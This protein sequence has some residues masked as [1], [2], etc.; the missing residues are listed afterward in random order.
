MALD[1]TGSMS[2]NGKM[3]TLK[4]AAKDLVESLLGESGANVKIGIVPFAQ[5]VNV[6]T[7][8][9][10]TSWIEN[11]GGAWK[12]CVGSRDYPH[13]VEDSDYLVHKA[14]AVTVGAQ[15]VECP[16]ELQTLTTDQVTL[17]NMING[18]VPHGSTYIPSGLIWAWSLLTPTEPFTEAATKSEMSADNGVKV[19]LVMTDGENTRAP[20]YPL[21]ESTNK[22]EADQLTEEICANVK[23]DDIVVYS[24]AF[25]V[26]QQNIKDVLEGCASDASH[27][28]DA[29]DSTELIE[30]FATIAS[31]LRNLSL[32]K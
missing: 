32:S 17:D 19:L 26:T 13:N 27:Y 24:I 25:S 14:Q 15:T 31:S 11:T 3:S 2:S 6:G 4:S 29:A 12:G 1:T 30:A 7:A 22:T 9:K 8:Y 28:F 16:K 20:T 10:S 18:L 21:H 23:A 5:Y